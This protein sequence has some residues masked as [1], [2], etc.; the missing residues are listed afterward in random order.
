MNIPHFDVTAGTEYPS[1]TMG[2]DDVQ[3]C[4][5]NCTV[6]DFQDYAKK[7]E[8]LGFIKY[9]ERAFSTGSNAPYN[10]NLFYNYVRDDMHIFLFF[11]A[12]LHI[13]RVVATPPHSLPS[14][15]KPTLET[16]DNTPCSITQ[17]DCNCMGYV[18]Q[19]SD[20]S[21]ILIDGGTYKEEDERKLYD[22][23]QA[24]TTKRK[25]PLV[26]AWMFTHA[27]V[28]HIEL[29]TKF[30]QNHADDV[31]ILAFAYNFPDAKNVRIILDTTKGMENIR[32]LEECMQAHYP[33]A[34]IYTLRT[35]QAY[36]FKG[37][38]IEILWTADNTYPA[39][40]VSFN[41]LSAVWRMRFHNGK[42]FMILG[43]PVHQ[44]SKQLAITYGDYLQ[45]DIMQVAHHGLL[46]GDKYLYQCI[47]PD[48]CLWPIKS[49]RFFGQQPNDRY[50]WCL[51]EGGCDYN[52]WLRDDTI[53]KRM[54]YH[55]SNIVT[56]TIE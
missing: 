30:M 54:H 4:I 22:V 39:T 1:A 44:Y 41:D 15:Q 55:C 29:A 40:Y 12:N 36:L 32:R 45:S 26:A 3:F 35:G 5:H 13:A 48:I 18:I 25:K 7:L 24:K 49:V 38:E 28:D 27:D 34:P 19:L 17:M 47:D 21:F 11:E 56:I 43:D 53:R 51:G 14:M 37:V 31:D 6:E 20:E 23:L 9:D 16:S 52:R 42:T 50:Q 8:S 46:G 33:N 2:K 10:A